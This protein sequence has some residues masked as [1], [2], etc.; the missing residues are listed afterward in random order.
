MKHLAP[1][2]MSFLLSLIAVTGFSQT[3]KPKQFNNYPTVINCTEAA[4][5]SVFNAAAGQHI[6]LTFSD[7]FVFSGN[8]TSNIVKYSNLQTAVIKSPVFTNTRKNK[9]IRK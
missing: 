8:V 5:G 9:I 2:A 4:L 7:N 6:S 1:Y 3:G